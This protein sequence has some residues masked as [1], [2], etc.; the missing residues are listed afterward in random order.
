MLSFYLKISA[1][2]AFL[3]FLTETHFIL[4]EKILAKLH[5]PKLCAPRRF[6]FSFRNIILPFQRP[7]HIT[8]YHLRKSEALSSQSIAILWCEMPCSPTKRIWASPA[9][10]QLLLKSSVVSDKLFNPSS[11]SVLITKIKKITLFV[12]QSCREDQMS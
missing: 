6:H 10:F 12:S 9:E 4:E 5:K 2:L 8:H 3:N 11:F 7:T 1:M